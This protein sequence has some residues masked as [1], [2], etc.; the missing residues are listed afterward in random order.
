MVMISEDID[1][2]IEVKNF[3]KTPNP[4]KGIQMYLSAREA[5]L[6]IPE[7]IALWLEQCFQKWMD[8]EG[9]PPEG[10]LDKIMGL[11]TSQGGTPVFKK[12]YLDAR[13]D[14]LC[15]RVAKLIYL[16]FSLSDAT[17]AATYV[18]FESDW[19][20]TAYKLAVPSADTLIK[21]YKKWRRTPPAKLKIAEM[22]SYLTFDYIKGLPNHLIPR[23]LRKQ[24]GT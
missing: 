9:K 21:T 5:G 11:T 23:K 19:N 12:E 1:L 2:L 13:D 3:E 8:E 14:L 10:S 17:V 20:D 24:F 7:P 22:S 15:L 16:G 6:P 18:L 4:L